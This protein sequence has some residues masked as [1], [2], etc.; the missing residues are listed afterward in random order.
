[1]TGVQ[2]CALS[3]LQIDDCV[4]KLNGVKVE[5]RA[6]EAWAY[7]PDFEP[8]S[9]TFLVDLKDQCK[10]GVEIVAGLIRD[11]DPVF[12][13]YGVYFYCNHRL[14]VKEL[15]AREVGYFALASHKGQKP[16]LIPR[17]SEGIDGPGSEPR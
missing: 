11:R 9:A 5:P 13:N 2:T 4:I 16:C 1:M 12:D 6:F 15:K 8:R 3:D 17:F 14:V 7:P 10:V